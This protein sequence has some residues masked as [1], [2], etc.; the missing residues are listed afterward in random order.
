MDFDKKKYN[1]TVFIVGSKPGSIMPQITEKD[2]VVFVNAS[3]SR[4]NELNCRPKML[5]HMFS[6]SHLVAK[7]ELVRLTIKQ[8]KNRQV[9]LSIK[10]LYKNPLTE[11][12]DMRKI[13]YSYHNQILWSREKK[14]ELTSRFVPTNAFIRETIAIMF[15]HPAYFLKQTRL[16]YS[17]VRKREKHLSTG[18]LSLVWAL[19]EYGMN[20]TYVITGIGLDHSGY[21]FLQEA[22]RG[23]I[24]QDTIA[25]RILAKNKF[26]DLIQSTDCNL[27]EQTGIR[28]LTV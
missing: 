4:S 6:N 25:L 10:I 16:L 23:H 11:T 18:L 9:G 24:F 7:T 26:A 15:R 17:L 20:K 21:S 5:V 27:C 2:I 3:I 22:P 28:M 19:N 8:Y 1:G 13:G 14:E 12:V